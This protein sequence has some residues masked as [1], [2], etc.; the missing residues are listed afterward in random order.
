MNAPA[1]QNSPR[2]QASFWGYTTPK[3]LTYLV[4]ILSLGLILFISWD[5]YIGV[6]FLENQVYMSYQLIVCIVFL[7][8]YFYLF[9]MSKRK[10][11]FLILASPFL[12]ISIP[13]LNI[14]EFLGINV[15]HD[16]LVYFCFIPIL[17][18]IVALVVVVTYVTVNLTT[19][20]F[21]S[22][23]IVL[24]PIVYM[25][26]LI[27]YIAE[28]AIN[29]GIKNFWYAIWWAGMT[30]TTVGCNINMFT[31]IGMIL[32]FILSLLGIIM[33]PLFTVYFGDMVRIYSQRY[34]DLK[35]AAK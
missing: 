7:I 33:L 9:A 11:R 30:F 2:R 10:L 15:G 18:G 35:K 26:G 20:V 12:L 32:G 28:K 8:E 1:S 29:P 4:L 34:R 22:Y 19:T 16:L 13:Y 5:T 27:F 6:D 31:G 3:F 23:T 24:L 17:R 14:I 21:M 25:S